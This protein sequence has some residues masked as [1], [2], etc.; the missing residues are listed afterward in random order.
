[1]AKQSISSFINSRQA[2]Y[3]SPPTIIK[4]S[5]CKIDGERVFARKLTPKIMT[6][7][8]AKYVRH[9]FKISL[10]EKKSR[11]SQNCTVVTTSSVRAVAM[12]TPVDINAGIRNKLITK[13]KIAPTTT[14]KVSSF[15]RLVGTMN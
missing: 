11:T 9:C 13:L 14:E 8:P 12:A 7:L 15:C 2:I 4:I 5:V 6:I 10:I 1:M 3:I